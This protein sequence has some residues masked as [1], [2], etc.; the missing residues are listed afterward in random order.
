ML[1]PHHGKQHGI[2][3]CVD[4]HQCAALGRSAKE[5][6]GPLLI[7]SAKILLAPGDEI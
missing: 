4:H 1:L 2:G 6:A 7:D 3:R 5:I